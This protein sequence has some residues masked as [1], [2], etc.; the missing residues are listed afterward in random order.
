MPVGLRKCHSRQIEGV[1]VEVNRALSRSS[2][3]EI[4]GYFTAVRLAT[5]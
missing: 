4:G 2:F 3:C 5:R 1:V